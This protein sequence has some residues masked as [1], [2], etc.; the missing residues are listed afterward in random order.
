MHPTVQQLLLGAYLPK[1]GERSSPCLQGIHQVKVSLAQLLGN[2]LGLEA[3]R[4]AYRGL[5]TP[6]TTSCLQP[7]P[8]FYLRVAERGLGMLQ[9]LAG[10]GPYGAEWAAAAAAAAQ[11]LITPLGTDDLR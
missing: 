8:D 7:P 10:A 2:S 5:S 6:L 4:Q 11:P 3:V 1:P 9:A